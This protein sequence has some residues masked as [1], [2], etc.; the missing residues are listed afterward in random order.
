MLGPKTNSANAT[1]KF[2]AA[3]MKGTTIKIT[4]K[5]ARAHKTKCA[6]PI[7]LGEK[8]LHTVLAIR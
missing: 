1:L 3:D 8:I 2:N 5:T 4:R 7:R 6:V